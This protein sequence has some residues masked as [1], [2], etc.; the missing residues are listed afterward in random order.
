MLNNRFHIIAETAFSHEGDFDYLIKQIEHASLG[1]ADYV[2]FQILI[3]P[4]NYSI[5]NESKLNSIKKLCFDEKQWEHV[6]K[7]ANDKGLKIISLPLTIESFLF[8]SK[9]DYT[10]DKY[11]LHSV[12]FNER[13]LIE[14]LKESI[15]DIFLGIGG[16]KSFEIRSVV[17]SIKK[18][19]REIILMFGFQSFP[20]NIKNLQLGKILLLN[21]AFKNC[22]IGYADH[23]A[24]DEDYIK[25]CEYAFIMGTTFFEKHIVLEKGEDRIDSSSGIIYKDFKELRKKLTKVSEIRGEMDLDELN[26]K[27]EVY[28]KKEKKPFIIK[29]KKNGD[30]LTEKDIQYKVVM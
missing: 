1:G 18:S 30:L 8:C 2:K 27:E 24:F 22:S 21:Q 3:D 28:K 16:R 9:F 15:K 11:E 23:T 29:S 6:F 25:I 5:S 17:E 12:C 20:T 19:E 10:I 4:E 7:F 14:L 26:E 13:P